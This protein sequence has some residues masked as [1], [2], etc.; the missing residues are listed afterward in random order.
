MAEPAGGAVAAS[1]AQ[2]AEQAPQSAN[3]APSDAQSDA[4]KSPERPSSTFQ[5]VNAQFMSENADAGVSTAAS[6]DKGVAVPPDASQPADPP[7]S[8][9]TT[10]Q[11][12]DH[13]TNIMAD[14]ATYGTRSRNRTGNARPNYAEDQDM[15][16]EYSSAAATSNKKKTAADGAVASDSKRSH[17]MSRFT[18]VN[19]G[20]SANGSATKEST[21]GT[22]GAAS[23]LPKKRKAAVAAAGLTST[24]EP[25]PAPSAARKVAAPASALRETNVMTFTKH[26][27]CLNKKGELVA[28]DGTK[29]CVN[30]T[31]AP[32]SPES[33][34]YFS[35]LRPTPLRH[36]FWPRCKGQS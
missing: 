13:E 28:D 26:K 16:F 30:G 15:D 5:A 32:K 36:N 11:A 24:P 4:R 29:L 9:K 35:R 1:L 23:T 2:A 22:P 8:D 27:S 7:K 6:L 20:S 25:S 19:S 10:Q 17:D 3:T 33:Q 34:F 18:A 14:A 12:D 31:F 21:P